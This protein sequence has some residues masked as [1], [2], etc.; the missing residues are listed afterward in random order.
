[1]R[2]RGMI[3]AQNRSRD[4]DAGSHAQFRPLA[5]YISTHEDGLRRVLTGGARV[6]CGEWLHARHSVHYTRLTGRFVR[7]TCGTRA[8]SRLLSRVAFRAVLAGTGIA[9]GPEV[10]SRVR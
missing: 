6:L 5:G 10:R 3:L 1:M 2:R 8:R 7:L 4:V 9:A